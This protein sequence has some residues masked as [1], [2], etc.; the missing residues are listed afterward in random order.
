[1][2]CPGCNKGIVENDQR[3]KC[4]FAVMWKDMSGKQIPL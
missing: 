2:Q 3:Y 4:D 1:M